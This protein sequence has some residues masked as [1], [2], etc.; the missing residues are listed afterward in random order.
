MEKETFE[1]LEQKAEDINSALVELLMIV[2]EL[3]NKI[4]KLEEWYARTHNTETED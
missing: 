3:Q 4:N 2:Q 1:R